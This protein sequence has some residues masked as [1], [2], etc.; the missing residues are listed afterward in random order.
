MTWANFGILGVGG[1]LLSVPVVLHLLM[2]PK[3][4][5]LVFPA[6]RFLKE[7]QNANRS[8]SRLRHFLL[9]L[10]RCLL[11][12]LLA[13]ALAGPSV[14]SSDYGNWLTL[15]GISFSGLLVGVVLL[16]S[17]FRKAKNWLLIGILGALFLGHLIYGGWA[18]SK[19]VN[20]ENV[21]IIGDGQE[22]VAALILIDTSPRM[23]YRHENL[24]RLEKAQEFGNWLVSQFPVD[25]QVCVLATD[26]DRPFFSV[27]VGAARRRID[28]L[29]V[30]F[31]SSSLPDS[32]SD[33]ISV[34][35]KAVQERK[36]IYIITDLTRQSWAGEKPKMLLKQ[37]ERNEGTSLFVIDVGVEEATN[38]TL[39]PL[40]LS[41]AEITSN[42]RLIID[43]EVKRQGDGAQRTI[44]M[45]VEKRDTSRPVIRDGMSI[46]PDE[47]F[48]S[49]VITKDIRENGTVPIKFTF[50][51]SLDFGIYHGKVEIVGQDGL[52]IDNRRYFTIRVGRI[53]NSLVI[54][55]DEVN[56]VVIPSLLAPMEK[57][58]KGTARFDV[59]T[60]TQGKFLKDEVDL[61]GYDSVFVLDPKPLNDTVWQEFEKY[62]EDGGGLSIFLGYNAAREGL[63]DQSFTTTAARRVIGGTLDRQWF[64][65]DDT[66]VFLSPKELSHPVFNL[67]RKY[68]TSVLWN[69]FPVY[70]H[71]GIEPDEFQEELPTQTLLRYGNLESAVI[72]R[73]IGNGKV[74]TMTSPITEYGNVPGRSTWNGLLTGKPYPTFMLLR[75]MSRYLVESDADSLNVGVGEPAGFNNQLREF[76]ETYQVFSPQPE[77]PTTQLSA[78]ENKV[79]YR[80]TDAPGHYRFK[81]VFNN[82]V[83]LRGFSANLSEAVTD[84]A[85]V[86]PDELDTYLGAER[87]QLAKDKN[88]IQ[89]QQGATR[90]GQEFYPLVVLMM[91]VVMAVEYLMSNRFYKG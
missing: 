4:K 85:R 42:G 30:T 70:V 68:E 35:E 75:G 25:S 34:L 83:V 84:L 64:S 27:D 90:R 69:R 21:Q 15:G 48:A 7:R 45:E 76:P 55:P 19:I 67:I 87:Y 63:P 53:K 8:R 20:S 10:M 43:S 23:D 86:N 9:L 46:F 73:S 56:P 36:E 91:L 12:G 50:G 78:I 74:L 65:G 71:W 31:N 80:F 61:S 22:P 57:V 39:A 47:S 51:E 77:K 6:M 82:E 62:V 59:E 38:F 29:E 1:L 32:L 81:G 49:Q 3:P 79:R 28:N 2:Q 88:E 44:K 5:E 33:G 58:E 26:N 66:P 60:M 89:R 37:L 16:L 18:A 24:T 17:Y 13:V 72:E 41:D 52:S 40:K 14:A 54:H 11:I